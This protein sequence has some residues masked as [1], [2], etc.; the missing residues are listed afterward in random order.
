MNYCR[1]SQNMHDLVSP[2]NINETNERTKHKNNQNDKRLTEKKKKILFKKKN[3]Y[4]YIKQL[5]RVK[6]S[7]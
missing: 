5:D 2:L 6:P 3:M 4:K 1:V 7:R